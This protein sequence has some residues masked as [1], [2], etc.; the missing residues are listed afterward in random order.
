MLR[1]TCR[2][3]D[4]V[5]RWG[6]EEFLVVHRF[7]DR[8]HGRTLAERIRSAI[9]SRDFI[10]PDGRTVPLTCFV[11]FAALP[12][13]PED[14]DALDWEEVVSIADEALYTAKRSGRNAWV[15]FSPQQAALPKAL[16]LRDA[17]QETLKAEASLPLA[18]LRWRNPSFA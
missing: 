1:E 3:A 11:G 18:A 6:G 9:A 13:Y 2:A 16:E 17:S 7:T 12:F 8:K 4:T 15:G 14:P 10:G 5:V